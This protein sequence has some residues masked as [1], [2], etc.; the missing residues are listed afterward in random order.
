MQKF[1]QRKGPR[2]AARVGT[3][4]KLA[5][6]Y[7]AVGEANANGQSG[8][9]EPRQIDRPTSSKEIPPPGAKRIASIGENRKG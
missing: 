5:C 8:F 9:T 7:D 2:P 3:L 4:M 1:L 6:R